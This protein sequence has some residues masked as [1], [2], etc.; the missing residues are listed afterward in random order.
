MNT[1]RVILAG[2]MIL[3]GLGTMVGVGN[4][5]AATNEVSGLLQQ[6]LFEE[7]ANHNL[8]AA[9]TAYQSVITRA[10]QD[11]QFEATAV[12]RLG[13]CYRKLGRTNEANAQYQ[14]ILSEFA[15]QT[16]LATLSRSYLGNAAVT[17]TLPALN[18]ANEKQR[19]L[20]AE[21]IKLVQQ[22]LQ[23][24]EIRVKVGTPSPSGTMPIK[25][26]AHRP[27]AVEP[28]LQSS[29]RSHCKTDSVPDT[30][31][32][33]DLDQ[34]HLKLGKGPPFVAMHKGVAGPDQVVLL[35]LAIPTVETQETGVSFHAQS[36]VPIEVCECTDPREPHIAAHWK[37]CLQIGVLR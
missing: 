4:A 24:E 28:V 6:G 25:E 15:D 17:S 19:E 30:E 7:E 32:V 27:L 23:E 14:R 10:Q 22:E 2:L 36:M 37:S 34:P 33:L 26:A 1:K 8:E 11:R 31:R 13:E 29:A 35:R 18:A 21:Q 3:T 16:D 12:F 20:L 9:I 5:R